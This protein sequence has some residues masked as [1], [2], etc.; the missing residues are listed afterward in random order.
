MDDLFLGMARFRAEIFP[1]Q[2][3]LYQKLATDGQ[4]PQALVIS[5]ADSRVVPELI[6]QSGPGQIFCCRNAGNIV[7]PFSQAN[8]GVSSAIEYAVVALGVRD[9]VVCGHSDCGAMKGLLHPE[10]L[11]DMPNVAAW[12]RHSHAA[13]RVV[14]EAYPPGRDE[15]E[16]LRALA[17]EN[18]VAQLN[19]L[20]THPSVAAKVARGQ[21]RLHGW[22]FELETGDILAYDGAAGRFGRIDDAGSLPVALP[23]MPRLAAE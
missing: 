3:P 22:F 23:P 17:L 15:R 18:V 8:G 7:P 11:Q 4:Q 13:H 12:L 16:T 9:I 2:Q 21:L 10:A 20:R 14:C 5:C 6:T 19:H 1:Q